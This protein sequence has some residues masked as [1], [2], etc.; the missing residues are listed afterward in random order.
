MKSY[1]KI[2]RQLLK[3]SEINKAYETLGAEFGLARMV[4]EKRVSRGLTQ[5]ALARKIGTKQSS[6]ARLESGE[7]NPTMAFLGK[8]AKALD[9]RLSVSLDSAKVRN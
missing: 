3:D 5:T 4:I 1:T 7:Y 9:A 6:I 2:K 8:V